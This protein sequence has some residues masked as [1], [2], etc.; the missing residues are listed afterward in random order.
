M[1]WGETHTQWSGCSGTALLRQVR[2][3]EEAMWNSGEGTIL[4][5]EGMKVSGPEAETVSGTE[6]LS[7]GGVEGQKSTRWAAGWLEAESQDPWVM[8]SHCSFAQG[9]HMI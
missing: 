3:A 5:A 6:G 2:E 4:K 9:C 8:E 7:N 1:V